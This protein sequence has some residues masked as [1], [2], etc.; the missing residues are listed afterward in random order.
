MR[1]VQLGE[2]CEFVRGVTFPGG[3]G[4]PESTSDS[5]AC[6]TTSGVQ[7]EIAW[8]SRRFIP[9][10]RVRN[11]RQILRRGDILIST[12]NSKE[13]VGKSCIVD[14]VPFPCTFGAFVTVA[15]P[16]E[17]LHPPYL[18]YWMATSSFLA[19][20]FKNSANT[21]NISNLRVSELEEVACPVPDL[22]DQKRIAAL[23]DQVNRLRSNRRYAPELSDT[24]LPAAFLKLF[25]ESLSHGPFD[26]LGD[27]VK[28]T[29]GGTP[30]RERPEFFTG[31]IPWLTSKDMRGDY[32]WGTEEHITREAIQSSAT[33][34]V[35]PNSVLVV[36]KSKI[37]MH[38]L[39][40]AIGKVAL[41][42]GQD[43]KSIQ[44]SKNLHHEFARFVLKFHERHLLNIARG[45]NTEGLTLPMLEELR[46]PRV[47]YA[48]Q[49]KFADLVMEHERLRAR[50]REA[51]RQADHL[52]QS[53][54]HRAFSGSL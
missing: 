44:C 27:L 26:E 9:R 47:G 15:R 49:E 36:V 50:Q 16:S 46:V 33:N 34:L 1:T 52:F 37:L 4:K 41:C 51:L 45:A 24:L 18:A 35:P 38:R 53:L 31:D 39:P 54:L 28:I 13:L 25:G 43:V 21:T 5:I 6:L 7:R 30:P 8:H 14:S 48:D 10:T 3:E 40:L 22:S 17:Q 12:A 42:H 2:V 20:C 19:W 29:G 11:D 32:I 23:L